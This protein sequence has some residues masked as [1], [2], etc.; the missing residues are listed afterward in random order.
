MREATD[1]PLAAAACEERGDQDRRSIRRP[2]RVDDP[3]R[4][5]GV[6]PPSLTVRTKLTGG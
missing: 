4:G 3:G 1:Q 6:C 2:P 5:L